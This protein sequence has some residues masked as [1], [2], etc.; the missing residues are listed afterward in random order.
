MQLAA[1]LISLSCVYRHPSELPIPDFFN[2]HLEPILNKIDKEKK[3]CAIMGDFNVDRIKAINNN[4]AAEFYNNFSSHFFTPFIIQPSR[5]RSKTLI[6]NILF[7]SLEY[8]SKSGNLLYELS[9]HLIQFLIIDDYAKERTLPETNIYKRD[10]SKFNEREFEEIVINGTNWN[11]VCM[12]H[13]NDAN[14]SFKTFYDTINYHLDE[15]APFKK[16][17]QKQYKL[18]LKPWLS[19]DIINKC[20]ER[21]SLLKLISTELDPEKVVTLRSNFKTLRNEITTEKR[22]AKKNFYAAKF[23]ANKNKSSEIWKNIRSLINIKPSKS[24]NLKLLDENKNVIN[25]SQKIANVFNDHFSTLGFKVQQKIPFETGSYNSY[26]NKLDE[27]GFPVINPDG[28]SF[29]LSPTVPDEVIKLIDALDSSKSAGPNS[30]PVFLLKSFK[31]FFSKWLSELVNLSFATGIFPDLLKIAK[32]TPIHKKESKLDHLNYRPISLLS[33]YS[34]IYEKLIYSRIYSYLVKK[35]LI[36][37]KQFGFRGNHSTTHALISLTEHIRNLIDNG[38]YV[39]GIFI[40]LEKAFDTVHH[41]ILCDKLKAY[42]LRGNINNLLKSYL[43]NR[44]QFVSINGFDSVIKDVTCGVPQG[45]SLGPLLFLL[46]INDFRLCLS[47]TSMGHFA[48][49]TFIIYNSTKAKTIETII[50]TELKLVIK[51]LRLNKLSLNTSKTELI[52]FHSTRHALNF[53]NIYINFN[54]KR[55]IPVDNIKYLGIF[56][57]K[58]LL[59]NHHIF[60]LSKKL[61]RA[62]GIISKLRYNAPFQICLQ[63]YYAIFYSHLIYGCNVWGLTSEENINKLQ[64][65]QNKCVRIMTFAPW[66]SSTNHLFIRLNLL[67]VREI[68]NINHLKLVYDFQCQRLPDDLMSL[69]RLSKDVHTTN[70]MLNS[71][72][73]NLLFIPTIETKT[74]GNK[75]IRYHCA[76]LWND[77]FKTG[78]LQITE[79]KKLQISLINSV[80]Q[81]KNTLKKHYLYR[82]Y[83]EI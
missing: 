41:D 55:L 61:S 63:V 9:D 74:Y 52:F 14:L 37:S 23:E 79:I 45:S 2:N 33:V 47:K 15:M 57:D 1:L 19:K 80:H 75:S 5:L 58:F 18:M 46:Y 69:F 32:V 11:E 49:D 83:L 21:D 62:N 56:I 6:D 65:L 70:L 7:N 78:Y 60:E 51:W 16:V 10:Y 22:K 64:V 13:Y 34:K 36:Y 54:G 24:A 77:T 12:L 35:N 82:Y 72:I 40:D 27:K 50:N 20:N 4:V 8:S 53:D 59:W 43:S 30:I 28:C 81:F 76:K 29:F 66:N 48:D 42:G 44:K 71:A 39:C 68:I 26:L 25:D 31:D 17:T 3:E 73:N 38:Q 67:K